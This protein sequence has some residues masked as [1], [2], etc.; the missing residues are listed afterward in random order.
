MLLISDL[1]FGPIAE[2]L[3]KF[4]LVLE[5]VADGK[6]INGSYW[7]EPEAGVIGDRVYVRHDTPVHSL[8]HE[9]CHVISFP[10]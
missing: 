7:G 5:L 2:L 6:T 1:S 9:A 3:G 10:V 4:E 8:L